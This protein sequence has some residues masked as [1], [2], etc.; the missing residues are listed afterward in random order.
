M[1]DP[2]EHE[3]IDALRSDMEGLG[4]ELGHVEEKNNALVDVIRDALADLETID[5]VPFG[6]V[7]DYVEAIM[8]ELRKAISP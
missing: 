2:F 7:A 4:Y 5:D 6:K 3:E 1:R 8:A